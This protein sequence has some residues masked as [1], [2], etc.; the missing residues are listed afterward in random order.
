MLRL[1]RETTETRC[2][3]IEEKYN[4]QEDELN[5]L[6]R[7]LRMVVEAEESRIERQNEIFQQYRNKGSRAHSTADQRL[8]DV[9]DSYESQIAKFKE[10]LRFYRHEARMYRDANIGKRVDRYDALSPLPDDTLTYDNR[11]LSL[12]GHNGRWSVNTDPVPN[13]KA[14]VKS[15]KKQLKESKETIK[16][17]END[18]ETLKLEMQSRPELKD[19]RHVQHRAKKLETMLAKNNISLEENGK[20]RSHST[21]VKDIKQMPLSKCRQHL[22]DICIELDVSDVMDVIPKLHQPSEDTEAL[23][24]LEKLVREVLAIINDPD[25]PKL[26]STPR[27]QSKKHALWCDKSTHHIVPMLQY[28]LQQMIEIQE[29]KSSLNSLASS[30]IPWSP[31]VFPESSLNKPT[32]VSEIRAAVDSLAVQNIRVDRKGTSDKVPSHQ[33]QSIIAHF[34]TLFDVDGLDGVYPRMNEIYTKLG[35]THNVLHTVRELLGLDETAKSTAIVNAVGELCNV[36]NSTTAHQ[37]KR[38]LQVE[39]LNSVISRL[40]QYE[41]FFPAF[42]GLMQQL[43]DMLNITEMEKILPAVRTLKLLA[44]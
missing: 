37:L 10:E 42:H 8:L 28:W 20:V 13:Y 40:Q 33:L 18:V 26:P 41:E 16:L 32:S 44:G 36:V 24:H 15:Y 7:K 25:A 12:A 1:S 31:P 19:L 2:K 5:R 21:R 6:K 9:I 27:K 11:G 29:L 39:D 17:L 38:L 35:E 23:L 14:V 43:M 30:L 22:K 3:H 4:K 34:Q